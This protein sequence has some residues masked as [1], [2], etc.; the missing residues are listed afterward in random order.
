MVPPLDGFRVVD[1]STWIG[2]AYCTK[3]LADGGAEVIKVESPDGDPLR[4]WSA[5]GATIPPEDDGALFNYLGASKRSV[6]VDA[7]SAGDVASLHALLSSVDAV[8]WTRGS[9]LVEHPSLAPAALLRAHP[10]LLVTAISPFGLEGPW[11]DRPATE[12]TLQAWSGGTVGLARGR[13]DRP[14]VYVG[15]QIGEWLAG[16]FGAIGTLAARRRGGAEGELVDVSMLEAQAM[17]LTYYPVT[18]N[19]QLGRPMRRKRFVA[20][21]GVGAASDGLVGLGCGTGQQWLDFCVLV[22]HPEWMEDQSLFLDRTALTP[23][24][25]AWVA[26]HTVEEVLDLASGFRIPNAPITNGANATTWAHF[27]DR[28][29]FGANPRDGAVNPQPPVRLSTGRVRPPEPAPRLGDLSLAEATAAREKAQAGDGTAPRSLPFEGLR[30]LDMTSFWAGPLTGHMLALLGAEVIHLESSTRPDGA[31]LVGGV[32]QTEDQYWERGPIFAAL[33]TNKKSLT[34]DLSTPT[35][36][37]LVR[38]FVATCDVVVENYTPRVLEQLGLD[39]GSLRTQ[40]PDLIMVRMPGFGLDGPWR[41]LSAFAFVIEDAAGLTWMTGHPDLLPFEPYCVGDPNAGLHALYGL[42]LALEHRRT[43]GEG[44]LV[45]AAM[46]DAAL[47]IAAE[48]MIESSAYGSLLGRAGNRGP[49]AAPQNLYQVA[50]PDERGRDDGWVAIA[51]ATDEQW[52]SLCRATGVPEWSTDPALATMAGRAAE[53]D[54]IDAFLAEW[55]RARSADDIVKVLWGAG[56]PVAKV[57]QPHDQP[58]LPQLESRCFFEEV[59]HPVIGPS[60]YSTLPMRF[61]RG[62]ERIHRRHAPLLGEHNGELLAEL[63]LTPAE[64]ETLEADGII[65]GS[66]GQ[67]A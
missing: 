62:P 13:P 65:G 50:G 46:V 57:M 44:G 20:T 9:P 45:E 59:E 19:D 54:R 30:V 67:G 51:V 23:T 53:H 52:S 38:R 56:V 1:L 31:R 42:L 24:I 3:L 5:S 37:D 10:H 58:E 4:R 63:G 6:V 36:V 35:G 7:G 43:T 55:C 12:F 41:D 66:L 21:P 16:L 60:R 15:G 18:F 25:D 40:R 47:N 14:P 39:Y 17:C 33:N 64:I 27:Q 61:S 8:V 26:D 48:Q 32:P 49:A 28:G 29:T 2:G 11:S 34:V 22:G